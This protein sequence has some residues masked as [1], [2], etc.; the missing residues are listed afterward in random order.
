MF[1][2]V[3]DC[4]DDDASPSDVPPFNG[5]ALDTASAEDAPFPSTG[6]P[7]PL[8]EHASLVVGRT[9]ASGESSMRVHPAGAVTGTP[10]IDVVRSGRP[11]PRPGI[12][13]GCRAVP[14]AAAA[15]PSAMRHAS[16]PVTTVPI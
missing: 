13:A 6:V 11:L 16:T 2:V 5:V 8:N 14:I 15:T 9:A 1:W 4:P 12:T 7:V 3:H 10:P